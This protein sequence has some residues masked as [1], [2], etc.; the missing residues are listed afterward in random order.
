MGLTEEE[1]RKLYRIRKTVMQM[2]RDRGYLVADSELNITIQDFIHKFGH[3]MKREDLIISKSNPNDT[4][5]QIY[6]FFP[7]EAK[8]GL[9][10]IKAYIKRMDSDSVFRAILVVQQN[11]TPFARTFLTGATDIS[12]KFHLE[13]FQESE[14]LINVTH[15]ILV[16][17]HGV[18]TADEKKTLLQRFSAKETQI[19]RIQVTDPVA[20]YFGMKRGQVMKILRTSEVAGRYNEFRWVV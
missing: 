16:P 17:K 15:H 5:D 20:R 11:L 2:L 13:V 4:S 3:N 19:P 1:I 6:I 12:K 8:V 18:L 9:N 7:E 10:T 14:L